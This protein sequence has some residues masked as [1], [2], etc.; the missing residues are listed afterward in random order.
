MAGNFFS[1]YKLLGRSQIF[2][3]LLVF[4]KNNFHLTQSDFTQMADPF[5]KV[6]KKFE[7]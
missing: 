3:L 2:F 5:E 7:Y 6:K 4:H 1:I